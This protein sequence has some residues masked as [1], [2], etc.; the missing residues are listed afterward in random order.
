MSHELW[1][2]VVARDGH[3]C[4]APTLDPDCGPCTG[5]W[6]DTPIT[7]TGY[8]E[9]G[10]LTVHHVQ[11]G[12]GRSGKRAPSTMGNL[13]TVCWGHHTKCRA[14]RIWATQSWVLSAMRIYLLELPRGLGATL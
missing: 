10:D 4:I 1:L 12:Y 13:V 2:A 6:S 3:R 14:G 7:T 5:L 9:P 8:F 11:T